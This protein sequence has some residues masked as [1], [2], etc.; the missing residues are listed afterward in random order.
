[1]VCINIRLL[2]ET[3]AMD[4]KDIVFLNVCR[5]TFSVVWFPALDHVRVYVWYTNVTKKNDVWKIVQSWDGK[6]VPYFAGCFSII[7]QYL[8]VILPLNLCKFEV[9]HGVNSTP[10]HK[11]ECGSGFVGAHILIPVTRW[12]C[13]PIFIV[14]PAT[15]VRGK[16][17]P[18][19]VYE[20]VWALLP[21]WTLGGR[22]KY[23]PAS[24]IKLWFHDI[25]VC[26]LDTTIPGVPARTIFALE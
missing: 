16:K 24:E 13:E 22:D 8:V 12:Y 10:T 5:R 23:F 11:N 18:V 20:A 21:A 26:S 3:L 6:H 7:N 17:H 4:H 25:R 19:L 14:R 15:C 9:F 1:M 2:F